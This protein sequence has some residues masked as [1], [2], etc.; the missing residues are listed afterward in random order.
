MVSQ[1]NQKIYF[2]CVHSKMPE[3]DPLFVR[4]GALSS[5]LE[6]LVFKINL[7]FDCLSLRTRL[8]QSG[9]VLAQLSGLVGNWANYAIWLQV[10]VINVDLS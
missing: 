2:A 3:L 6:T 10:K 8:V 9:Q 4:L 7:D 1:L 5:R